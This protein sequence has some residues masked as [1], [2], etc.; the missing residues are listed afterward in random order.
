MNGKIV[1]VKQDVQNSDIWKIRGVGIVIV[2]WEEYIS[3]DILSCGKC[4]DWGMWPSIVKEYIGVLYA[5][6]TPNLGSVKCRLPSNASGEKLKCVS[7]QKCSN[8]GTYKDCEVHCKRWEIKF[9]NRKNRKEGLNGHIH[10]GGTWTAQ[11]IHCMADF[12]FTVGVIKK[13]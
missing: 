1:F 10:R 2:R 6:K 8:L 7:C 9:K 3:T 13:K 5:T 11:N 4:K 12:Q